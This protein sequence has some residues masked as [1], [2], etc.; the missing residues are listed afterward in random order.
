[1]HILLFLKCVTKPAFQE[2]SAQNNNTILN[3]SYKRALNQTVALF[4]DCRAI[5]IM[6]EVSYIVLL[7]TEYGIQYFYINHCQGKNSR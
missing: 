3:F 4:Q 1:M 5:V 7:D 2:K 6:N